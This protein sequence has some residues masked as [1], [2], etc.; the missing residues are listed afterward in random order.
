MWRRSSM[1]AKITVTAFKATGF[2]RS[3]S[4]GQMDR[5]NLEG[6]GINL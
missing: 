3:F 4:E 2:G 6:V 1:A 5:T